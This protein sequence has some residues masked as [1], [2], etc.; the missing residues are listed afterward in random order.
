[1][2][3]VTDKQFYME[4]RLKEKL[5]L[6]IDRCSGK[7]KLDNLWVIDGDEGFGKSTFA[8]QCAYYVSHQTGRPFSVKNVFFNLK[9]MINFA[10]STEDQI[11]IWDEAALGGLTTDWG[12]KFQIELTKLLMVARKKRHFFFFN[13]PKFFK[14][15]EYILIDRAIAL[16]HVYARNEL[17]LGR[18]CYFRKKSKEKLYYD[19]LRTR[20]RLYKT[21]HDFH[22]SFTSMLSELINEEAYEKKK[23]EAIMS[24]GVDPKKEDINYLKLQ[25]LKYKVA[26]LPYDQRELAFHIGVSDRTLRD[27]KKLAKKLGFSTEVG[28]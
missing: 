25:E 21:H 4:P 17:E 5:D 8:I 19:R 14:L 6:C 24:V 11:I 22:G 23:D 3:R 9:D 26:R 18:F 28:I 10:K 27:W 7:K 12:N 1:M 16:V 15:A 13:I 2:V 20:Q